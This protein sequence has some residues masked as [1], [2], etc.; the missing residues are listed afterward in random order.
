MSAWP[1][2]DVAELA[3]EAA[4]RAGIEFRSGYALRSA[5]RALELLGIEWANR[6]LNLW[7]IDG[8]IP[9]NLT[10]GNNQYFVPDDTVDLIEHELRIPA[11]TPDGNDIDYPLDR[12]TVSQYATIPNKMAE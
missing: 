4:E 2:F 1:V 12:F 11:Q 7:A 8:P 3:E 10:P 5:R 9:V 6:G